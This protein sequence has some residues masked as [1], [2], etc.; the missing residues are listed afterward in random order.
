MIRSCDISTLLALIH[1]V[2][3]ETLAREE[4]ERWYKELLANYTPDGEGMR[5]MMR[6]TGAVI[7]GTVALEFLWG[8]ARGWSHGELEIVTRRGR[9]DEVWRYVE[10]HFGDGRT[11]DIVDLRDNRFA[12]AYQTRAV[13]EGTGKTIKVFESVEEDP[14]YPIPFH[15]STHMMNALGADVVVC[16]YPGLTLRGVGIYAQ[17]GL[18]SLANLTRETIHREWQRGFRLFG[19][20]QKRSCAENA[21]CARQDR[22][23]GDKWTMVVPLGQKSVREAAETLQGEQVTGWRLGGKTCGTSECFG[24]R[25]QAWTSM[26]TLEDEDTDAE[27]RKAVN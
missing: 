1:D 4:M 15:W 3:L 27:G 10:E 9:F 23:M 5:E 13:I 24:S 25:V 6:K 12:V 17:N 16:P 14:L 20:A 19:R 7:T 22:F 11:T 21:A 26:L 8:E 2:E 18:G